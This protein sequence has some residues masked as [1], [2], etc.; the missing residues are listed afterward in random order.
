MLLHQGRQAALLAVPVPEAGQHQQGDHR[1][2]EQG[3]QRNGKL[4]QRKPSPP[5]CH[6]R[7]TGRAAHE[8]VSGE[9]LQ[10]RPI[11]LSYFNRMSPA[12]WKDRLTT[13]PTLCDP[14]LVFG[15]WN[16]WLPGR[17][18]APIGPHGGEPGRADANPSRRVIVPWVKSS[19]WMPTAP[20]SGGADATRPS[21]EN[22]AGPWRSA[23]KPAMPGPMPSRGRSEEHT[24]E[25]Q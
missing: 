18:K 5:W 21:A 16:S 9:T 19:I 8:P 15:V 24:S 2:H 17:E 3:D 14:S 13:R 20:R 23:A 22:A 4:L 12:K 25:L 6:D 11:A 1:H 7:N 10:R